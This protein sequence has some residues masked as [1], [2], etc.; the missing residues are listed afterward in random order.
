MF[1]HSNRPIN[2][3]EPNP[4]DEI[5]LILCGD[6]NGGAESGAV[7]FVEDGMIDETFLEDGQPVSSRKKTLPLSKPLQDAMA[8][9]Q[10]SDGTG[11]TATL[12]V[13]ELMSSLMEEATYENPQLSS[14]MVERLTRIYKSLATSQDGRMTRQDV[15]AWLVKINQQMGRGDEYRE[16]AKQ[17]GWTDPN[18]EDSYQEQKKRVQ[19]PHEGFLSLEGFIQVYQKELEAGKF[20]G[21][22]HDMA[23]LGDAL[24]DL[25]LFTARYDRIY[26]SAALKPA[27]V[28]DTI[29]KKPCPNDMEPS[30][31]LPIAATFILSDPKS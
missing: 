23:V 4:E 20:W 31:H 7:R 26:H 28:L 11:P 10:R 30:D 3:K 24:P 5:R 8:S 14:E 12:V 27:A 16:A 22:A 15:E 6:F 18:P 1:C 29:S 9:I 21:I 25:G 17:M 13:A 2:H 19:M